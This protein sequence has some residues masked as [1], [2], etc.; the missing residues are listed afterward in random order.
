[1]FPQSYAFYGKNEKEFDYSKFILE[2]DAY[3]RIVNSDLYVNG[4]VSNY[5]FKN[6]KL[7][8]DVKYVKS[9]K[10]GAFLVVLNDGSV[11]TFGNNENYAL[12][13]GKKTN[14]Y[15]PATILALFPEL[16]E[17][18]MDP[19]EISV[20]SSDD[21]TDGYNINV[22]F[23][24]SSGNIVT[25]CGLAMVE[26]Y[27]LGESI[28]HE[29]IYLTEK[30]Y[31]NQIATIILPSH[32][33]KSYSKN[34]EISIT[35]KDS[36]TL[37]DAICSITNLPEDDITLSDVIDVIKDYISDIQYDKTYTLTS[38]NYFGQPTKI[39]QIDGFKIT[40]DKISY[41]DNLRVWG[42]IRGKIIGSDNCIISARCY[43]ADGYVVAAPLIVAKTVSDGEEF[44]L[45]D[46]FYVPIGTKRIELFVD[47]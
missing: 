36:Y 20:L 21:Y 11:W 14:S 34:G 45:E 16:S 39:T 7:M 19:L 24:D 30:S 28:Y 10:C 46:Y 44:Y 43:D 47:W 17:S 9:L 38:Y 8:N 22:Q 12:G 23:K 15:Y 5:N 6:I 25:P 26:I 3:L 13:D 1:M 29:N 31:K 32:K 42:N 35:F 41:S 18:D 27:S 33:V 37:S 40:D 4:S 2:K